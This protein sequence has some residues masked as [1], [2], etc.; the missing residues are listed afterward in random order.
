MSAGVIASGPITYQWQFNGANISGATNLSLTLANIIATNSGGYS[1]NVTTPNGNLSSTSA[2][3]TV[4]IEPDFM[5]V[6]HLGGT[7][8]DECLAVAADASGN[9]YAAGYFSGTTDFGGTNL[10]SNGGEDGFVAKFDAAQSLV[11]LRQL[12][13]TNND[14]AN[15]LA[16]DNAGNVIVAGQ[17]SDTVDF[18]GANLTS[19]GSNDVFLAKFDGAGALLWARQ[20]GSTNADVANS[21]AVS[22]NGDIALI[23][24]FQRIATFDGITL[25]NKNLANASNGDAFVARYSAAGELLWAKSAGGTGEDRARS[26]AFDRSGNILIAGGFNS[27][28]AF[29]TVTL[30]S[31]RKSF[32]IFV[33]KYGATGNVVWARSP[34]TAVTDTSTFA[35]DDEATA[36]AT[37]RDGNYFLAGYF[38][39]IGIFGPNIVASASTNAPDLF[40]T[41]Y[42]DAGNVLWVR[43]AGGV[44]TDS[45]L[46]LTTDNSG[47][48]LLAGSFNGP[49]QFGSQT[50]TGIGGADAF[51]AMFDATGNLLKLRKLGGTG[52]DTAQAATCDGRGNLV[53]G[54][55]HTGPSVVGATPLPGSGLRD[56]FVAKLSLYNPDLAPLITTQP[57]K[58]T[59]GYGKTLDLGVG[60]TS[61]SPPAYQWLFNNA[62]L[63][64]ATNGTLRI[65]N[66]QYAAVGDYSVIISNAF[67]TVMSS[68][69]TVTVEI[70]PEFPWLRRAGGTG[71]DQAV[72]LALDAQT[73]LYM[74][75]YFTGTATFTNGFFGTNISLVSTGLTDIFLA[76]YNTAGQILWARRAGGSLAD[77]PRALA[78]DSAGNIFLAG[79]FQSATATFGSF[80][81]INSNSNTQEIFVSKFDSQGNVLWV[82]AAGAGSLGA[83]D[84]AHAI[85]TDAAGNAYVTGGCGY[86]AN[87]GSLRLTNAFIES[88]SFTSN[89]FI[90]KFDSAGEVVW[91]KTGVST[92]SYLG[93]GIAVD[94][95]TN[96]I[97]MGNFLGAANFGNGYLTNNNIAATG[98][99]ES[100]VFLAKYDRNG[101]LIWAKKGIGGA[102]GIGQAVRTDDAG[103]IYGTSYRLAFGV[104]ALV[105]TKYDSNGFVTWTRG[106]SQGNGQLQGS[107]L[108]LDVDG[109]ILMAG[110]VTGG[111]AFEGTS[112]S[113]CGF[114]SKHRPDGVPMWVMRAGGWCYGVVPDATGGAYLAGRY[115]GTGLFGPNQTN[116]LNGFGG[117]DIFLVKLGV[118][119]PTVTPQAFVKTIATDA[120][121]T[122]QVTT[123]GTGPFAYQWRFNGT[124]IFGATGSTYLLSGVKWTNAGLYSVVVSNTAGRFVSAPAAVNVS[125][126]LYSEPSGNDVK[127]T[128]DGLFTLQ[129]ATNPAGPFADIPGVVSPHFYLTSNGPLRFFRL[130]SEPFALAISNQPGAGMTLSGAGISGYNFIL[131]GSTNLI[132]WSPVATNISPISF[133]ETNALPMRFYRA[134]MAQ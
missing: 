14:R 100:S 127:L 61:G 114:V 73:N 24:S 43:T 65:L 108:A 22:T 64:G 67:G 120:G 121:T 55:Y 60:V 18:G 74:A 70:F 30:S 8:N 27:S 131:L 88:A 107:S 116:F 133:T 32:E 3:L 36:V 85:A 40:L 89:F 84:A 42:D 129:S 54:G 96:I 87:F 122:L 81:I 5:W 106:V 28:I 72:A 97:V 71:D 49:A 11:W 31:V 23:G 130:K 83:N 110:G 20:A 26:V 112:L 56:A 59:V 76:K 78:V 38:Q 53:L 2:V 69:A 46:A 29:D 4:V 132:N 111:L 48:A 35:Y 128:W 21:L 1:V 99:S 25:T 41:K 126:K 52:D 80:S 104:T 90:A 62:V 119:S 12:G 66:F 86:L 75:G 13:G 134:V 17:F 117:N 45:A 44:A 124:N 16:L 92:A 34:G 37:D 10:T 82:K 58:Q 118:K 102:A 6:K 15:S 94:A 77:S 7:N 9:T 98:G 57:M 103:N 105:L 33:A 113:A 91:A 101:N 125:P 19:F 79:S 68:I 95:N 39:A 93:N 63:T 51:A 123:T 115:A 109:N 50:L 47:N